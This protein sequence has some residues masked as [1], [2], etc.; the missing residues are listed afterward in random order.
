MRAYFFYPLVV[1]AAAAAICS[2]LGPGLFPIEPGPQ[3]GLQA[4]NA[5]VFTAPAL[6]RMEV[7]ETQ[8]SYISRD[9][10]WRPSGMQI[11]T[12]RTRLEPSPADTGARLVLDPAQAQALAGKPLLVKVKVRPLPYTNASTLAVSAQSP[13]PT[14]WSMQKL[15]S[16]PASLSFHFPAVEGTAPQAIGFWPITTN[17]D[18]DYGVEILEVRVSA[19]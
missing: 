6:A 19:E 14:N 4:Q 5:L 18:Y 15:P 11:A 10:Y 9:D 8:V 17:S 13:G 2:S 16:D 12:K 7:P 3:A 1:L